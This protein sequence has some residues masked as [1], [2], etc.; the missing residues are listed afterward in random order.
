M[1][2]IYMRAWFDERSVVSW[3]EGWGGREGA[4][5]ELEDLEPRWEGTGDGNEKEDLTKLM[6]NKKTW[7]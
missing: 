1:V 5:V 6:R 2:K 4:W 3:E 7:V